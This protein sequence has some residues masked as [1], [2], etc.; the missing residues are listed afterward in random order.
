[1]QLF[2]LFLGCFAG[3]TV[4][5]GVTFASMV[6]LFTAQRPKAL[7]VSGNERDTGTV[8][9]N[10]FEAIFNKNAVPVSFLMRQ[11]VSRGLDFNGAVKLL[12]STEIIAAIYF[13]IGGVEAG[14]GAVITRDRP[15]AADIWRLNAAKGR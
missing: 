15:K 13:I 3:K 10:V 12:S 7:T 1:M 4:Y 5:S 6:G 14:Q 9:E 2:D 11:S 8:W